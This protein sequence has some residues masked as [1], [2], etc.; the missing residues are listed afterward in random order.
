MFLF[1]VATQCITATSTG[2]EIPSSK[3]I[4]KYFKQIPTRRERQEE[5][6]VKV[7]IVFVIGV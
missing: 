3:Q 6:N 1:V 4:K 7:P 5:K 2:T